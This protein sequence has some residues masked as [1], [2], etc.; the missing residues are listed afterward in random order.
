MVKQVHYYLGVSNL[1]NKRA[2]YLEAIKLD[3][4]LNKHILYMKEIQAQYELPEFVAFRWLAVRKNVQIGLFASPIKKWERI[5]VSE[6]LQKHP[7]QEYRNL[8][9]KLMR[10][11]AVPKLEELYQTP[12]PHYYLFK[13]RVD[14]RLAYSFSVKFFGTPLFKGIGADNYQKEETLA[15]K[16][17][18]KMRDDFGKGPKQVSVYIFEKQLVLFVISEL[19][20]VINAL[21]LKNQERHKIWCDVVKTTIL[22]EVGNMFSE[23]YPRV[24][25]VFVEFDHESQKTILL[26][27]MCPIAELHAL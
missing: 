13:G 9:L 8:Y 27:L 11:I 6:F 20:P 5:I 3:R 23:I 22:E 1:D 21:F 7:F 14:S 26:V 15:S 18:Q 17:S 24:P 16:L 2:R 12:I 25:E 4:L 10:E 19:L